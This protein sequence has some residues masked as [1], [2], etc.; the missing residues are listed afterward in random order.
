[1]EKDSNASPPRAWESLGDILLADIIPWCFH[2]CDVDAMLCTS[3]QSFGSSGQGE[4]QPAIAPIA[5]ELFG[6]RLITSFEASGWPGTKLVNHKA[7]VYVAAFDERL[8]V[9]MMKLQNSL[10]KWLHHGPKSLP[11]DIC[12]FKMGAELPALISVTHE[13]DA[14][15]LAH[16]P[17][18]GFRESALT[19]QDLY[20]WPGKY[21]C[22][23]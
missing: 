20:I 2:N 13:R 10:F 16:T 1:M 18:P 4:Y 17:P 19:P 21:F 23:V 12:F 7:R 11:E 5:Q 3:R 22:D 9:K 8:A 15:I 14:W 6:D